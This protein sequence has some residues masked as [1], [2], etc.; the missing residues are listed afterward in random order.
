[1]VIFYEESPEPF[2]S[3]ALDHLRS[4]VPH[5]GTSSNR[6]SKLTSGFHP[7]EPTGDAAQEK[8]DIATSSEIWVKGRSLTQRSGTPLT[9]V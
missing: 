5:C 8:V 4:T 9:C 1:M 2:I 7:S 3:P 6:E